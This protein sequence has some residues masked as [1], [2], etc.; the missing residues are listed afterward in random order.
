MNQTL[1]HFGTFDW[2]ILGVVLVSVIVSFFRG[3]LREAIS[4]ATWF[5]AFFVA[6]KFSPVVDNLL[7]SF[8]SHDI[9]RYVAS[10]SLI[11]IVVLIVGMI[12][13]KMAKSI[14]TTTGLGFLDKALGIVFGAARGFLFVIIILLVITESTYQD[15]TWF[16]QSTLAPYFKGPVSYF[17]A[18]LP[19]NIKSFSSWIDHFNSMRDKYH[20]PLSN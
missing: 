6:I 17:I 8:I 16:K 19:E 1:M 18:L 7:K 12:I 10:V 9:T 2:V 20:H 13:N 11:F 15:S 4:L 14:V 5:L 3:F